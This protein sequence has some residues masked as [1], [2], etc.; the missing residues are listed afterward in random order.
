MTRRRLPG[1]VEPP[2]PVELRRAR[3][4]SLAIA[5][6]TGAY[7]ISFGAIAVAAGLTPLQTQALSALMFT[8]GS[9]FA[10]VGVVASGGAA[11]PAV[12]AALFL[13]VR[14]GLYGIRLA[15]LLDPRGARRLATAQFVIDETTAM[16]VVR[17]D[18]RVARYAFWFT[19]LALFT[20]WNLGTLAGALAGRAVGDPATYGLDA[21]VPAA[22]LAL[23]WPR[24]VGRRERMIALA[25]AAVALAL[26]PVTPIGVPVLV[27][28]AVALVGLRAPSPA[29]R[30]A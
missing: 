19:G 22:F 17:D 23:L 7:G 30:P 26:V 4:D 11:L 29:G 9:Q 20:L 12:A 18:P 13:G 8:G 1:P 16:A 5:V 14:N 2:D 25:G 24:L 21:A 3:R 15:R 10:F 27:A 6:A 28:A